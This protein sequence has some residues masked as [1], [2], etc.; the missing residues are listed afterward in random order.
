MSRAKMAPTESPWDKVVYQYTRK[1]SLADGFQVDVTSVAQEAGLRFPV[2]M[3][4]S[5]YDTYVKVPPG[6][7]CQ[8]ESGRLWDILWMLRCQIGKSQGD[9]LIFSLWV[10]NDNRG[11]KP[12]TLKAQCGARDIDDPSPAITIMLTTED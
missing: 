8:D 5:V 3:T 1:Q 4:R 2:F 11:A 6:V 10:R 9:R 12:V 7:Q